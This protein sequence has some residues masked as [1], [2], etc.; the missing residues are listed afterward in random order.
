MLSLTLSGGIEP[1]AASERNCD[2]A[3]D[4]SNGRQALLRH[5]ICS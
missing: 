4:R 5:E 3:P 2:C 1:I